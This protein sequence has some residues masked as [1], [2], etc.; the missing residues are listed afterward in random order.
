MLSIFKQNIPETGTVS[1]MR[2]K[3]WNIYSHLGPL[4][5]N[6]HRLRLTLNGPSWA[7][8][9]PSLHLMT[10]TDPVLETRV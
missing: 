6:G 8:A 9:F 3:C 5:V 2:L 7:G 4:E 1:A 10:E